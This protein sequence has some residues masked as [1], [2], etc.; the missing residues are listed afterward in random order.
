MKEPSFPAVQLKAMTTRGAVG[1]FL[2]GN[3]GVAAFYV[4]RVRVGLTW[5]CLA[6]SFLDV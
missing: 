2:L 4:L 5:I 3:G 6:T 1:C